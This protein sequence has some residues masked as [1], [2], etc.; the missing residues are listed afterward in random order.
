MAN[1]PR[2]GSFWTRTLDAARLSQ[3]WTVVPRRYS[4]RTARQITCDLRSTRRRQS[5]DIAGVKPGEKW[6]AVWEAPEGSDEAWDCVIAIK[7][8]GQP[9]DASV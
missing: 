8:L 7:Y 9:N 6:D 4:K 5:V 3:T 2:T 1:K